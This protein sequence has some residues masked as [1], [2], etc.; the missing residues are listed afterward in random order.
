MTNI[1]ISRNFV[2]TAYSVDPMDPPRIDTLVK[3]I[4]TYLKNCD[5]R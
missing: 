1:I 5:L 2:C 3:K 4:V